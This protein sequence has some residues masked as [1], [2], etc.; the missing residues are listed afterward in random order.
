MHCH[1]IIKIN[2]YRSGRYYASDMIMDCPVQPRKVVVTK[3]QLIEGTEFD[4]H[5][6][7]KEVIARFSP[8]DFGWQ[9]ALNFII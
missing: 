7:N 2:G 4:P 8:D 9:N 5:F 3:C 1:K 6:E